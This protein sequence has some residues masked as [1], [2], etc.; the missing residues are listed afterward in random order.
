M[1]KK[2]CWEVKNCGRIPGGDK[3]DEMGVCPVAEDASAD[4]LNSGAKGGR[5]CWAVAGTFC[6]GK[7]QGTF[8]DKRLSCMGCEFYKQVNEEEGDNF[9]L[10]KPGQ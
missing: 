8:A 9:V 3:V 5:I 1:A 10:L 6:G 2:N 7:K 4:G